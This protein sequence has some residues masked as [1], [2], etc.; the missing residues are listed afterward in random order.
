MHGIEKAP[1]V[2]I[3]VLNLKSQFPSSWVY[4]CVEK[5]LGSF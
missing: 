1:S 3:T 5:L 4:L 2:E